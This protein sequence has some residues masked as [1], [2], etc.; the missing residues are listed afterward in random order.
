M[1]TRH[2]VMILTCLLLVGGLVMVFLLDSKVIAVGSKSAKNRW[3]TLMQQYQDNKNV[4]R[5]IFVKYKGGSRADFY[6]YKKNNNSWKQIIKCSAYIG[7]NGI[8]KKIAGDM[9]TPTGNFWITMGFG[10]KKNPGTK[11]TYKKLNKYLYWSARK[12]DY[13]QL[14][15]VRKFPGVYG[16]HLIDYKPYYNYALAMDFNKKGVYP[17]GSAIFLHCTGKNKYTA[18]CIAIQEKYMK[19]VLKNVTNHTKICIYKN[20]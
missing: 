8:N 1:Q 3:E 6:M 19:K 20:N 7:K 18:G 15:D 5:L 12:E 9:R 10:I 2:K 16:E 13:N 17:K 14:V 4:D 11:I